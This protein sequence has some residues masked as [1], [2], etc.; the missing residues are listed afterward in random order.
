MRG[1][2]GGIFEKQ[3]IGGGVWY[4]SG[5]KLFLGGPD[6]PVPFLNRL[7]DGRVVFFC[8]AGV[9]MR[10]GLPDFKGL[11][12]KLHHEYGEP[13]NGRRYDYDRMLEDLENQY[14]GVRE[15]VRDILLPDGKISPR[16]LENHRNLLR[17]A[18]V[19]GGDGV[20]PR[21]RLV[22]TNFDN[23]FQQAAA[24]VNPPLVPGD[25]LDCAPKLPM[26][27]ER[28]W[29]SLVH[30]HGRITED[31]QTL[32]SIVLTSSDFGRAYLIQGW[33]RRFIVQLLREWHVAF[34]GYGLND[35]PMRYL[36]DAAAEIHR[37]DPK[38]FR[39]SYAFVPCRAGGE[40][41][42]RAEWKKK[43][44]TEPIP[45][46]KGRGS[47]AH[48]L[49]WKTLDALAHLKEDP[50]R[51]RENIAPDGDEYDAGGDD[52]RPQGS[53]LGPE[54]SRYRENFCLKRKFFPNVGRRGTVC[55]IGW[56]LYK[57][58]GLFPGGQGRA[59]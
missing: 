23:R 30:L 12:K 11:V 31:D 18:S 55:S 43:G 25:V 20:S 16:L 48:S 14:T 9:S 44:I 2:N 46:L 49:L 37:R 36:M 42:A 29:A 50:L 27:E 13:F 15:K 53:E 22:T 8:G 59:N 24:L 1:G 6:I 28:E 26:P 32:K 3:T 45:Y 47:G 19:Q 7:Q 57:K 56:T 5:M 39:E 40:D 54:G 58:A 51:S 17:L 52:N 38:S 10:S 33:A 4:T 41:K 34:V 21:V 35:P